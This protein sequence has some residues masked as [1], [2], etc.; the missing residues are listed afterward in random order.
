MLQYGNYPSSAILSLVLK[1]LNIEQQFKTDIPG[2]ELMYEDHI[3]E[4]LYGELL[5]DGSG[6]GIMPLIRVPEELIN[7]TAKFKESK[8]HERLL[9][10]T[11][12]KPIEFGYTYAFKYEIVLANPEKY[13]AIKAFLEKD[14]CPARKIFDDVGTYY[15]LLKEKY[16]NANTL[17]D[18]DF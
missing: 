8:L 6:S 1:A 13:S 18:D 11:E 7:D 3:C 9:M 15:Q 16:E 14:T 5:K 4:R 12:G 17:D 10:D 2:P